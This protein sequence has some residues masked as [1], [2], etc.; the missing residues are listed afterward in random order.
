M[1]DQNDEFVLWLLCVIKDWIAMFRQ[2]K[3][4]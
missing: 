1:Y 4:D 3:L 2:D